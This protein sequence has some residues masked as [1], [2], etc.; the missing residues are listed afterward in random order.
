[1]TD[2]FTG[3]GAADLTWWIGSSSCLLW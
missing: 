2:A 1:M 3:I